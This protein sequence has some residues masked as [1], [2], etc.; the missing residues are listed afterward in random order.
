[1]KSAAH[2]VRNIKLLMAGLSVVLVGAVVFAFTL[3]LDYGSQTI[4]A[5]SDYT[6][7]LQMFL[8][9][10]IVAAILLGLSFVLSDAKE[11]LEDAEESIDD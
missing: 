5:S 7:A 9:I 3:D 1:M 6:T 11:N 4:S 2:R 10:F 8:L